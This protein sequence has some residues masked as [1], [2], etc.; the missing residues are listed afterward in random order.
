MNRPYDKACRF[1]AS[2]SPF[3]PVGV[4]PQIDPEMVLEGMNCR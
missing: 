1:C 2:G 4:D 3:P